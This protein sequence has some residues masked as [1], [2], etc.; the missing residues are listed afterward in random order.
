MSAAAAGDGQTSSAAATSMLSGFNSRRLAG[1]YGLASSMSSGN[2]ACSGF[3]PEHVATVAASP[4]GRSRRDRRSRRTPRLR[5]RPEQIELQREPPEPPLGAAPAEKQRA[6]VTITVQ[7]RALRLEAQVVIPERKGA[8]Q[9]A[10][11][12]LAAARSTNRRRHGRRARRFGERGFAGA[13]RAVLAERAATTPMRVASG[14]ASIDDDIRLA[15]DDDRRNAR[16]A[17]PADRA[18]RAT[19]DGARV[20]CPLP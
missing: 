15:H 10:A 19:R 14:N 12:L 8:E 13:L 20:A 11:A 1:E 9:Q 7:T 16:L 18:R 17:M 6:G 2:G 4:H 3:K 5:S